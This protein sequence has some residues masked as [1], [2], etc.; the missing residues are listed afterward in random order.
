MSSL[1]S[2]SCQNH[3]WSH[4]KSRSVYSVWTERR[5]RDETD[6]FSLIHLR[7]TQVLRRC[8]EQS[9][10]LYPQQSSCSSWPVRSPTSCLWWSQ[11]SWPTPWPRRSSRLCTTPS[12]GSRNFLI[13]LS[14][15]WGITSE[16]SL[17]PQLFLLLHPSFYSSLWFPSSCFHLSLLPLL[18]TQPLP[19][20]PPPPLRKYNIRVEDIMVRDVRY[21]T[22]NSS[23]RELQEMLLT[24]QLKTLALVESRGEWIHF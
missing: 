23:Y 13:F 21:I 7:P 17:C 24:G 11:S 9:P 3:D 8:L 16:S 5:D 15:A 18:I 10:T 1:I 14:W 12:Y 4:T 6:D 2:Y 19:S 22:L 20:P